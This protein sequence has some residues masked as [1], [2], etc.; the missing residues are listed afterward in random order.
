M[1]PPCSKDNLNTFGASDFWGLIAGP[2]KTQCAA[3]PPQLGSAVTALMPASP[4]E[5]AC[6]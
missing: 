6:A 3:A 4:P 2:C 1:N 5:A